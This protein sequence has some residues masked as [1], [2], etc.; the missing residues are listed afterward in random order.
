MEILYG[1]SSVGLGHA[2][3]SLVLAQELRKLGDYNISWVT[4]EPSLSFLEKSGEQALPICSDLKTLSVA[5]EDSVRGGR[6]EDISLVARASSKVGRENY[7]L[8]RPQLGRFDAIIQDEF[9]ETMFSFMWDRNPPLPRKRVVVTDYFRFKTRSR[10]PIN[11][12]VTW[13]AN[14]MIARAYSK[15]GLRIFGDEADGVPKKISDFEIVGPMLGDLPTET[16]QELRERLVGDQDSLIVVVSI[17]GT[18]VGK[19]LVDFIVTNRESISR[20]IGGLKF[21]FLLGPRIE[22]NLC[23][24]D[25]ELAMYVSF[26]TDSF[27]YFKAADCVITQAG[28]STLNEVSA[29]GTPC[30]AIPIANHWEQEANASRFSQ[31]YGFQVLRYDSLTVD[32]LVRAM[33]KA[34]DSKYEPVRS[35]GAKKAAELIR[36]YLRN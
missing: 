24:K 14:R 29:M 22:R 11:Q 3:R 28:A 1:V 33:R 12:I 15:S 35:E 19:Q 16:R 7:N 4:A 2:R 21:V 18:S 8:L 17:G 32:S 27:P 13:Y 5:M 31:K 9:A 23:P 34:M 36:A 10:N 20:E 30:V 6:L 26:T 25:S